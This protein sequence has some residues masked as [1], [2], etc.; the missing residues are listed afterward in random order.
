VLVVHLDLGS[1]GSR[2]GGEDVLDALAAHQLA[3]GLV[4][5]EQLAAGVVDRDRVREIVERQT[6]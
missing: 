1:P 4:D 2:R 5:V 6:E 3:R